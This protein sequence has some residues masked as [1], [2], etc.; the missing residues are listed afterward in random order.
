[1][2]RGGSPKRRPGAA[3][4]APALAPEPAAAPQPQKRRRRFRITEAGVALIA[5]LVSGSSFF[6]NGMTYLRGSDM[7][8]LQPDSW[9][10]YRDAGPYGSDL[11]LSVPVQ[12]VN[13][14]GVD[15]GDVVTRAEVQVFSGRKAPGVFP[16]T[17][18]IEPVASTE[19]AD[20][21]QCPQGARCITNTGFYVIERPAKLLDVPGG[22]SRSEY[23]NFQLSEANCLGSPVYCG[24]FQSFD[25][26]LAA[27]RQEPLPVVRIVVRFQFDG[28]HTIEC[29]LT[30]SARDRGM[31]FDYLRDKGWT[32]QPC[33]PLKA[34]RPMGLPPSLAH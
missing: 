24:R 14:A 34:A 30:P 25:Q 5:L 22:G 17:G 15:F 6:I 16:I 7:V 1:M 13:A 21:L 33:I 2:A 19:D 26:A 32:E 29:R 12:I 23:L 11:Y 9:L 3:K 8:L 27:L 20:T 31:I 28:D 4:A 18:L 10:M